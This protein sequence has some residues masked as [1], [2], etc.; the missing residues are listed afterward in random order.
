MRLKKIVEAADAVAVIHDR[1]VVAS[2]GYGGNGTPDQLFV[3]LE[4]RFLETG[5]PRGLTLV[6]STGQGDMKDRGLNRLA[7]EGL[8]RRV[9]GGYFGL[10]PG[11]EKLIVGHQARKVDQLQPVLAADLLRPFA[12][13]GRV[14]LRVIPRRVR[15][16]HRHDRRLPVA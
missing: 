15:Q 14:R 1:D 8:V 4:K 5:A 9:V 10:S 2:A 13:V 3:A 12:E 16:Q 11:I 7:H 6:F